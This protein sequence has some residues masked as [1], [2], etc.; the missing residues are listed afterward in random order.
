MN[1]KNKVVIITGASDG[2]GKQIA[3]KL[4]KEG[5]NLALIA[6][7]EIRLNEVK[8]ECQK[9]GSKKVNVYSCDIKLESNLKNV[10]KEII[11]D[12]EKIDILIN[13]TGIWQK[14]S[15]TDQ[16]DL[17]TIDDVIQTNLISQIKITNLILPFLRKQT[18][19]A[20][21][22]IISKSGVVAQEGQSIYTASKFGMRGF[23][24][25]LKTE[26]KGSTVRVSNVYQSGT[27]TKMFSK[28]NETVPSEK[29]TDPA[30]LADVIVFMLSRP[31]KIWLH[32][33]QVEY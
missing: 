18:E 15:P 31:E 29:F 23:A 8:S 9:L 28:V 20:I 27:N 6:R 1:L 16:I 5:A 4:A 14:M 32:E 19:A 17:E 10:I 7:N 22:N 12:F 2:I 25:V 30:D 33:V 21:I 3:L 13:D 26:L 24:E 11:N